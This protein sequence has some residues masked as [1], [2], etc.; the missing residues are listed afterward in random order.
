MQLYIPS[1]YGDVSLEESPEK[2]QCFLRTTDLTAQEEELVKKVLKR[3][4]VDEGK[5]LKNRKYH[6]PAS[7][8]RARGYLMRALKG[9]QKTILAVKIDDP[10]PGEPQVE[11]VGTVVEAVKKGAEKAV[12]TVLPRG[13]CPAPIY[14]AMKAREIRATNVLE[15]FLTPTQLADYR[16]QGSIVVI[17]GD[18]GLRYLV[19]HRFSRTASRRGMVC[20]LDGQRGNCVHHSHLPHAEEVLALLVVLSTNENAWLRKEIP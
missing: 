7:M 1:F 3:F 17:G 8:D 5:R 6:L 18:S 10:K 13:G 14:D 9:K 16:R 15:Q 4:K 12:Q 11:Q 19:S 2:D 20:G